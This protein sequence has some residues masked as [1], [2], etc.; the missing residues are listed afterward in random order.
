MKSKKAMSAYDMIYWIV[1]ILFAVMLLVS[2]YFIARIYEQKEL[3]TADIEAGLFKN[4]LLYSPNGLSYRDAYTNRIYTGI[5]DVK[6]FNSERLES[7]ADFGTQNNMVAANITLFD[8]QNNIVAKTYYNK[9]KY[10]DW[11]PLSYSTFFGR[12]TVLKADNRTFVIY[13]DE[14]G[15]EKPGILLTEIVVPRT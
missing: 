2:L 14:F 11:L 9:Q 10:L 1:R 3:D 8:M 7:A 12:G 13:L 6:N 4:Y 5:L 15:N